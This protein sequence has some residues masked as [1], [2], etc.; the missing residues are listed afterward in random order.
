VL[1]LGRRNLMSIRSHETRL[2]A[3]VTQE[4]TFD[5]HRAVRARERKVTGSA[6]HDRIDFG[7]ACKPVDAKR[8]HWSLMVSLPRELQGVSK[9]L[10]MRSR[11][12][13]SA[14]R[15]SE[16]YWDPGKANP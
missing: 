12:L 4:D 8:C 11:N 3:V 14:R 5:S 16:P 1:V 10:W 9:E 6:P 15:M 13:D 7:A 2:H